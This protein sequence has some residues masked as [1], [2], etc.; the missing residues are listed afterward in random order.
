SSLRRRLR[1]IS[2]SDHLYLRLPSGLIK[3]VALKALRGSNVA[4]LG[5]FGSFDLEDLEGVPY[6]WTWEIGPP[7]ESNESETES[8]GDEGTAAKTN[9]TNEDIYDDP[10]RPS[11]PEAGSR[12]LTMLDIQALKSSGLEGQALIDNLTKASSSFEKRT[13]FSQDKFVRRK[14]AKHLRLFTPIPP[15]LATL[16]EYNFGTLASGG[17]TG[18]PDKVRGMRLDTVSQMLSSANVGAGGRYL[19]VDGTSG[20]LL[21][22]A[23][24]ERMGGRGRLIAVHDYEV[25]PE[26]EMVKAMNLPPSSYAP[27]VLTGVNWAQLDPSGDGEDEEFPEVPEHLSLS[28]Y[29]KS[30]PENVKLHRLRDRERS[31]ALKKYAAVSALRSL[32]DEILQRPGSFDGL[33]V[34]SPHD[35]YSVLSTLLPLL[36]GSGSFVLHSPYMQPLVETHA[37]LRGREDVVNVGLSEPWIRRWQ[38][39]PGRT[40]PEMMTSSTG[41]YLLSG[42]RV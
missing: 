35:A 25:A 41:G 8:K 30:S 4:S 33:L 11:D 9:A 39:L 32:R 19:V 40:H 21:I 37:A 2:S 13:V 22:A 15:T 29:S 18:Q 20:G 26:W 6:G 28:E 38:V 5:K 34:S 17:A 3:Y 23:C 36:K 1:T 24:L 10:S 42:V 16:V 27:E 12:H 31:K 14:E 7:K